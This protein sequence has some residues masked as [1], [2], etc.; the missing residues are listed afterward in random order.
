MGPKGEGKERID[1]IVKDYANHP[2]LAGYFIT[3]EPGAARF[4]RS[5]KPLSIFSEKDPKHVAYINLYPNFAPEWAMGS[6]YPVYVEQ[7]IK[8]REAGDRELRPLSL[9]SKYDEPGFFSNLQIVRDQSL[10]A[11]IPVLEHRA[12]SQP[13]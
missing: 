9:S 11:K 3:D 13:L 7:F 1:A 5:R 4:P 12:V 6:T 2:A 10:A 8:H